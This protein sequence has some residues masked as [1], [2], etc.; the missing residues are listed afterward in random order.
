MNNMMP[1][2]NPGNFENMQHM[3]MQQQNS[4]NMPAQRIVINTTTQGEDG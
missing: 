2:M 1:Q 3:Y 4:Q